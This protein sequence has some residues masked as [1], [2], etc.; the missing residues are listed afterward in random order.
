MQDSQTVVL[1]DVLLNDG[2]YYD[3]TTGV[4][5]AP[6]DATYFFLLTTGVAASNRWVL[7]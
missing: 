4:F 5:T 2:D 1:P 3:N 6:L 7:C